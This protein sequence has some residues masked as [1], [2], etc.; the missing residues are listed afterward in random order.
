MWRLSK[1][2]PP[3]A[4]L[5][6][7]EQPHGVVREDALAVFVWEL[8]LLYQR[9]WLVDVH[10]RVVVRADHYAVRADK[11]DEKTKRFRIIRDRVVMESPD[12]FPERARHLD[13]SSHQGVFDPPGHVRKRAAGV[14]K[15][16]VE[17]RVLVQDAVH[18]KARR[19]DC[20]L[21]RDSYG[22]VKEG[23]TLQPV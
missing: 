19:G 4:N 5:L 11:A 12:V 1:P 14:E 9:H 7:A 2:V 16:N 6:Q 23:G 21:E 17:F 20:V 8:Q 22:V 13:I 15:H 18:D 10:G 3:D